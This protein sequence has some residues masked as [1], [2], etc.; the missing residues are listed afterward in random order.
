VRE[1]DEF[2]HGSYSAL[3]WTFAAGCPDGGCDCG[4]DPRCVITISAWFTECVP[5][6]V[7]GTPV[8]LSDC[9]G[10]SGTSVT[11]GPDPGTC[12]A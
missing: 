7:S 3:P 10:K 4:C 5:D 6:G 1:V 2:L 12:T 9:P 11:D 8:E